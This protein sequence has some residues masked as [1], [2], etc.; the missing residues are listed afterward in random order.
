MNSHPQ[1]AVKAIFSVDICEVIKLN[2]VESGITLLKFM[3][4]HGDW[5]A[6][7]LITLWTNWLM[8]ALAPFIVT[9]G[10]QGCISL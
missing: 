7:E 8:V 4:I 5:M 10:S 9:G 6:Y 3:G 1:S 2:L